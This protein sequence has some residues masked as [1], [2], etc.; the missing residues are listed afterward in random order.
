MI[1]HSYVS[2]P[3]GNIPIDLMPSHCAAPW[4]NGAKA[5]NHSLRCSCE[6]AA[7][8]RIHRPDFS[9]RRLTG[10]I[11]ET[12]THTISHHNLDPLEI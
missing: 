10:K 2:L 7:N 1:F 3:E 9:C 5:L 6:L 4:E 11:W 12:H 8:C